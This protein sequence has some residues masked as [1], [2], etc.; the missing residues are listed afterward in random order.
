MSY[1]KLKGYR[2]TVRLKAQ[3]RTFNLG[4]I[5]ADSESTAMAKAFKT[6]HNMFKHLQPTDYKITV[7]EILQ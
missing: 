2:V 3:Q 7:K 1:S 6:Y 4:N 5:M